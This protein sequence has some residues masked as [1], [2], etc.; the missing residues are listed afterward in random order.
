[1]ASSVER[2]SATASAEQDF[3]AGWPS[4][5]AC[6]P[7]SADS[8]SGLG[9]LSAARRTPPTIL[10]TRSPS[11]ASEQS[12][13]PKPGIAFGSLKSQ[14]FS[15]SP[16]KFRMAGS[17]DQARRRAARLSSCGMPLRR[18]AVM[19]V[20]ASIDSIGGKLDK[21]TSGFGGFS[22]VPG[23]G[24]RSCS[25]IGSAGSG[26]ALPDLASCLR[27]DQRARNSWSL[28]RARLHVVAAPAPPDQRGAVRA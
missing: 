6:R 4:G 26:A 8:V 24:V 11:S 21:S 17:A 20:A 28:I 5:S 12:S 9:R 25:S 23:G 13:G 15:A 27:R 18:N 16:M 22:A 3:G 1:V 14:A 2:T 19:S 10:S 7:S